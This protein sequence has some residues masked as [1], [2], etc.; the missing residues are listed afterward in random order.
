MK[1]DRPTLVRL[2]Q[3]IEISERYT[4]DDREERDIHIYYNFVG[5]ILLFSKNTWTADLDQHSFSHVLLLHFTSL[6][7]VNLKN[8][9]HTGIAGTKK[10]LDQAIFPCWSNYHTLAGE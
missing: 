3:K 8:F 4:V 10:W 2:I 6:L 9:C 7:L 1:L 5:Y